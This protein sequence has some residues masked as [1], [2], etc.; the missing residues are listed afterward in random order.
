[1]KEKYLDEQNWFSVRFSNEMH[2]NYESQRKIRIIRKSS[3]RYCQDCFQETNES[4]EKHLKKKHVWASMSHNFKSDIRFYDVSSNTNEKMSQ[5]VYI[6]QIL[7]LVF[8]S[9]LDRDDD[10][11]LKEDNDSEHDIN[12]NNILRKWN[13]ENELKSYFNCAS[14]LNL[15]SIVNCWQSLK[16][17][18]RKFS[19]WDE[20]ITVEL[21]YEEWVTISQHFINS[22]MAEMPKRLQAMINDDDAMTSY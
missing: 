21:I 5:R 17:H 15:S 20:T 10:F 2:F 6:D 12:K 3:Q 4:T 14:F 11:C 22:K 19:H 7:K 16:Q 13:K 18:I 9:W 8:K 1:M